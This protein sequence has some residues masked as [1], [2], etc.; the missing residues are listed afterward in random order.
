MTASRE[1]LID[2]V[3]DANHTVFHRVYGYALSEWLHLD[4]SMAQLKLIFALSHAP[5]ADEVTVGWVAQRLRIG[6][7]GAS[8]LVDR[9]VQMGFVARFEDPNDRRR[10]LVQL[11]DAGQELVTRLRQG[12]RD[13][14]LRW[15]GALGDDDLAALAVGMSALARIAREQEGELPLEMANECDEARETAGSSAPNGR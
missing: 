15:I 10:T 7:P 14:Y 1:E 13:R 2:Q 11:T 9:T 8:H 5:D 6:L 12:T 4:L 3:R